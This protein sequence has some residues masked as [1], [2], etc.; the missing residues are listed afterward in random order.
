MVS[1]S[2]QQFTPWY[3]LRS[4]S[5]FWSCEKHHDQGGLL[6]WESQ[7]LRGQGLPEGED[8]R[9]KPVEAGEG[10]AAAET[11]VALL[12]LLSWCWTL[13]SQMPWEDF[14]PPVRSS[15]ETGVGSPVAQ[16][17]VVELPLLPQGERF[18]KSP[19]GPRPRP[20]RA[21]IRVCRPDLRELRPERK[22]KWQNQVSRCPIQCLPVSQ[23]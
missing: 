12:V 2:P 23:L 15:T 1:P 10:T 18:C 6:I 17:R 8:T 16:P 5:L 11:G 21:Q 7:F 3:H 4:Q 9:L 13:V 22:R 19:D 20:H 14:Y